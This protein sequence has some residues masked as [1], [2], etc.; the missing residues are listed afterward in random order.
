MSTTE[1]TAGSTHGHTILRW[2][3]PAPMSAAMLAARVDREIGSGAKFHTCDSADLSL[4]DL[5]ALLAE[6]GK[7]AETNGEWTSDLSKMCGH[8]D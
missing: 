1:S 2:L 5:L 6:R 3:A 7:I 8:D 4:T